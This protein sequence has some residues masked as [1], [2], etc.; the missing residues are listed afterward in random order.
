MWLTKAI[1]YI[2]TLFLVVIFSV[3]NAQDRITIKFLGL[4]T[5]PIPAIEAIIISF[6]FGIVITGIYALLKYFSLLKKYKTLLNETGSLKTELA[7]IRK[8]NIEETDEEKEADNLPMEH[9]NKE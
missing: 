2:I 9:E 6:L 4:N 1:V 7:E 5:G 8:M 3:Q